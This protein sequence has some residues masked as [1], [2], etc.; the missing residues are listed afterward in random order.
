MDGPVIAALATA[1]AASL[2]A[3]GSIVVSLVNA[4]AAGRVNRET[5]RQITL[6]NDQVA[7]AK[8]VRDAK[9]DYEY[10]ARRRLYAE[11]APIVFQIPNMRR[12]RFGGSGPLSHRRK[13]CLIGLLTMTIAFRPCIA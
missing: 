10:A 13:S 2:A 7:T 6:L 1:S 4:Y 11:C 5:Q 3:I 8:G 12:M 9:R